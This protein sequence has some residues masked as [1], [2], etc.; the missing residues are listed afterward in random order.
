[1]YYLFDIK[2]EFLLSKLVVDIK[3]QSGT[4]FIFHMDDFCKNNS[5][6][7]KITLIYDMVNI[8]TK[9]KN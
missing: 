3:K 5:M 6:P 1:M 7:I 8:N 2:Y 9:N 4:I